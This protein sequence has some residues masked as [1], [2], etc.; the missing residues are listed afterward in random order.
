MR[1]ALFLMIAAMGTAAFAAKPKAKLEGNWSSR[2]CGERK[3]ERRITF[4][5]DGTFKSDDRV[6]PCPKG[7]ACVWSGIVTRQGK[8]KLRGRKVRLTVEGN[9]DAKGTP[10]PEELSFRSGVLSEGKGCDYSRPAVD[11]DAPLA[12]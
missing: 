11:P 10:L 4:A 5:A 6:S 12:K 3:Y 7:A 8:Y 1:T 2:S 9:Q